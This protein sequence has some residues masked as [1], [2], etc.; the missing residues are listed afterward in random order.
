MAKGESEKVTELS[1]QLNSPSVPDGV[2]GKRIVH[3][4]L[5]G[6]ATDGFNYQD[7]LLTKYQRRNGHDVTIITSQWIWGT[8]GQLERVKKNDYIN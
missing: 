1:P 8:N 2:T 4:V 3:L 7:N 6:P 5:L